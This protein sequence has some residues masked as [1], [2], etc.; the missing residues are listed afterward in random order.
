M[1]LLPPLRFANALLQ[2]QFCGSL[3]SRSLSCARFR[4]EASRASGR[5]DGGNEVGE[6]FLRITFERR[7]VVCVVH[8]L[9]VLSLVV[10]VVVVPGAVKLHTHIA[11]G[12]LKG[13][14]RSLCVATWSLRAQLARR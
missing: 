11:R 9:L 13:N 10:V 8:A 6:I 2:G 14:G 4:Y 12:R 1:R 7:R 3:A 5:H